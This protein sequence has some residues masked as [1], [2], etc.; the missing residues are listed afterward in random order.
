MAALAVGGVRSAPARPFSDLEETLFSTLAGPEGARETQQR[1]RPA[2]LLPEGEAED[3]RRDAGRRAGTMIGLS[4]SR[5]TVAT[6]TQPSVRVTALDDALVALRPLFQEDH[7]ADGE[8]LLASRLLR[9]AAIE[10]KHS[11]PRAASIALVMSDA[12]GFT[13]MKTVPAE[14]R[15]PLREGFIA[16]G[17]PFI[18]TDDERGVL[19][20]L[21]EAGFYVTPGFTEVF[22]ADVTGS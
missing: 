3:S 21:L 14:R 18:S 4:E 17:K 9:R 10:R 11:S 19:Q 12:L 22:A 13:D 8:W 16:L 2:E 6:A 15:G 7:A 5:P 1:L 20:G